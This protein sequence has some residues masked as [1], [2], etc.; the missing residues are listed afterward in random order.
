MTEDITGL[1]KIAGMEYPGR[2]LVV[3]NDASGTCDVVVYAVT[4]RSPSSRARRFA[5]EGKDIKTDVTNK[6]AIKS[7]NA[8]LLLYKAVCF[9]TKGWMVVSNGAQTD[10][11][12]EIIDNK[13]ESCHRAFDYEPIDLLM[14]AFAKPVTLKNPSLVR[15]KDN[16]EI[17]LTRY[18]PDAPNFT[19]RISAIIKDGSAA[20]SI[21]KL[22]DAMMTRQFYEITSQMLNPGVGYCVSTY[23]GRNVA[24]GGVLPSFEGEPFA[25][26]LR[27]TTKEIVN[28]VYK[29]LGP[30]DGG[31]DFRV[32]VAAVFKSRASHEMQST[33][34]NRYDI[35]PIL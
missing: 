5:M 13:I 26:E 18:E 34:K 1:E 17:D 31:D 23:T 12:S 15:G 32:A 21:V 27:G 20:I 3:G 33:I 2:L 24:K 30:K 11:I 16:E 14:K 19:P 29:A 8:A 10:V 6:D 9:D 35:T 28:D 4:G 22:A 7:G 25:V